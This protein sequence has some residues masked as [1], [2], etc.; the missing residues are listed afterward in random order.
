MIKKHIFLVVCLFLSPAI[1]FSLS[2]ADSLDNAKLST[3]EMASKLLNE[4]KPHEAINIIKNY[5]PDATSL[6]QYYFIYGKALKMVKKLPLAVEK[7]TLAYIYSKGDLREASLFERAEAYFDMGYY[8]ESMIYFSRFLKEFPNSEYIKEAYKG[9][10]DSLFNVG[11]Y[12]DALKYYEKISGDDIAVI[13]KKANTLQMLGMVKEANDFYRNVLTRDSE[14]VKRFDD[15]LYCLGENFMAMNNY[16]EAKRYF[17]LIQ[18]NN[19]KYKASLAL[20]LIALNESNFD[21]S[22]KYLNLAL[23]SKDRKV[24][25]RALLYL[26]D[27]NIRLKKIDKAIENL[28][29]IRYKY[30]Y[31][32]EYY[33]AMLK[34]SGLYRQK[35]DFKKSLSLLKEII[36]SRS[37]LKREAIDSISEMMV[38]MINKDIA[39][40]H[41]AWK[42]VGKWLLDTTIEQNLLTIADVL[43]KSSDM[44]ALE[45]YFWLSNNGSELAKSKSFIA[46]ANFYINIG[47]VNKAEEYIK[48]VK[49]K[50]IKGDEIRRIESNILFAKGLYNASLEQLLLISNPEEK[51]L[52]MLGR[53]FAYIKDIKKVLKIYEAAVKNVKDNV[54]IYL[55]LADLYYEVNKVDEALSYYRHALSLEPS[56]EWALYRIFLLEK[57]DKEKDLLKKIKKDRLLADISNLKMREIDLNKKIREI[58]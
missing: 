6:H 55:N 14:Y 50:E 32:E 5:K 15:T 27:L 33:E 12:R 56:N 42:S 21:S 29:E 35:D 44:S 22:S 47:E 39:L 30:P 34:L 4:K 58:F 17:S 45:I 31:G 28:E 23:F 11:L 3:I 26:S 53:L 13:V 19:F 37:S 57:S 7:L 10:A 54:N 20:G 25:R 49:E 24:K 16:S 1:V 9:L 8:Y 48:K 2:F 46:L 40:F 18:D 36:F 43:K 52:E 41:E 38:S 51:D